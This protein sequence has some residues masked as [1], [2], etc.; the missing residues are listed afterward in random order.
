MPYGFIP[1]TRNRAG[2]LAASQFTASSGPSNDTRTR[3]N[4]RRLDRQ[5]IFTSASSGVT[6]TVDLTVAQAI[7]TAA[8]VN[9]NLLTIG[10][11]TRSIEVR[12]AD[13]SGFTTG[14]VGPFASTLTGT[15]PRAKDTCAAFTQATKRYW[16]FTFVW[17]GGGSG[18][19]RVGEVVLGAATTLS[20]GELDGSGDDERVRA[21]TVELANG[22][23]R[24]IFLAG[25]VLTRSLIFAEFTEAENAILRTLWR[26]CRG[27]AIPLLWCDDWR[28]GVFGEA[29][30]RC[31]YGHLE[32]PAYSWRWQDFSIVKPPDFVIRSQGREVGA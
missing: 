25:P 8:V 5:F 26:D 10:S 14:V 9:H 13:D 3:L 7:D 1:A 16:R 21:P 27:P 11:G 18:V 4:D 12:G 31:L 19:L 2:G 15:G 20:R 28:Q 30:Q 24:G 29:Q 32:M 22:G 23:V 6:L 17:G